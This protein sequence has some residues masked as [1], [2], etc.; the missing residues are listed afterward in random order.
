VDPL[1]EIPSQ[2]AHSP[3]AYAGNNPISMIDPTGM[4]AEESDGGKKKKEDETPPPGFTGMDAGGGVTV[5]APYMPFDFSSIHW[6]NQKAQM[7]WVD[8]K[9]MQ[10]KSAKSSG[11]KGER[12]P[13]S[14]YTE[15]GKNVNGWT[16]FEEFKSGQGPEYS[17]FKN[18]HP[19]VEDLKKSW[20][21]GI[22]NAKFVAGGQK[23]LLRYDVPYG[24]AGI[25]MSHTLTEQIIGGARISII[26][27]SGGRVYIV[28]NTMGR[29]SY[30]LHLDKN[31][32]RNQN[33]VTPKGTTYH[34]FIWFQ[35]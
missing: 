14:A 26:P 32:S 30:H 1:A 21:V 3:Y 24:L 22:A 23:P 35:Y 7:G 10:G 13:N 6:D 16:L 2:I 27:V 19:M 8:E 17:I 31:V 20:I 34:R 5:E 28:D 4:S 15:R 9:G 11:G 25:P 33:Q 18:G 12:S 29:N